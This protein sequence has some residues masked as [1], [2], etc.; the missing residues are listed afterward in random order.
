MGQDAVGPGSSDGSV[1]QK[2][3]VNQIIRNLDD[4]ERVEQPW[5]SK[6]RDVVRIYRNSAKATAIPAVK[7][8]VAAP[9]PITFNILY[10]NTEVMAPAIYEQPPKPV[11]RPRFT[12]PD[13]PAPPPMG[14]PPP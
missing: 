7:G 9:G 1:E 8:K 14:P 5:R 11:V 3:N 6:G 13:E 12:A 4:A 10:A 2:V